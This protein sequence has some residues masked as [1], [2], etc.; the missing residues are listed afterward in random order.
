MDD[1]RGLL[2]NIYSNCSTENY[3]FY[4]FTHHFLSPS[5]RKENLCN[6]FEEKEIE[7]EKIKLVLT[8][9][10]SFS[11]LIHNLHTHIVLSFD[12]N[13]EFKILLSTRH[14]L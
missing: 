1:L 8:E 7:R 10:I 3:F 2:D 13:R 5:T 12:S 6:R 4:S 11:G 9:S 14:T